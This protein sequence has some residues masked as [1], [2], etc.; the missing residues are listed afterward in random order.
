MG[1]K[2]IAE[3][4]EGLMNFGKTAETLVAVIENGTRPE[5]RVISGTLR[6]I[7]KKCEEYKVKSPAVIV[8]GEVAS[9]GEQLFWYGKDILSGKRIVVTRPAE[10]SDSLVKGLE[11]YGAHI[12]EFPVIKISEVQDLEPLHRALNKLDSYSWL[13]F[14]SVNGVEIFFRQL[15]KQKTDIR[16]LYGLKLAAVGS[17]TEDALNAKGLFSDYIPDQYTTEH[18]LKGILKHIGNDDKILLI[19]SQISRPELTKGF[20]DNG[21]NYDEV[22]VYTTVT[23]NLENRLELLMPELEKADYIT[24]TSP[25]AVNAFISIIR[26]DMVD[27]LS[28]GIICIGPVTD[29]AAQ[30]KGLKVLGVAD[31][32]NYK[33]IINKILELE[34]KV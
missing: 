29:G 10:Q 33:G 23:S 3:I 22:A 2:N 25:S 17:V 16:K 32:H 18:L 8:V 5:Q 19:N 11:E 31:I 30:E 15:E 13:V 21:I 20:A 26:Q 4:S 12:T 7:V 28:A 9:L 6:N 1:V 14:T 27:K 34:S 24:F